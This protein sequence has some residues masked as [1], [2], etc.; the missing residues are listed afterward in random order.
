MGEWLYL[1]QAQE[2]FSLRDL[3][4]GRPYS[5]PCR[6]QVDLGIFISGQTVG[7]EDSKNIQA[8]LLPGHFELRT[9]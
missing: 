4:P 6:I 1:V 3:P 9:L 5:S 8:M 2:V 7:F